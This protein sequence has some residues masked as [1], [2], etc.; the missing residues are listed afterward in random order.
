MFKCKLA[1]PTADLNG[2]VTLLGLFHPQDILSSWFNARTLLLDIYFNRTRHCTINHRRI[3]LMFA[4][5]FWR[6][7]SL[8]DTYLTVKSKAMVFKVW[9]KKLLFE[10][11][12][13]YR[14]VCVL[15]V[16]LNVMKWRTSKSFVCSN[17]NKTRIKFVILFNNYIN[18]LMCILL[19]LKVW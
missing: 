18:F 10:A 3:R 19:V 14:I 6:D 12:L 13:R 5:K 4:E 11:V 17:E 9:L 7:V 2:S 8:I 16:S 1:I 15:L